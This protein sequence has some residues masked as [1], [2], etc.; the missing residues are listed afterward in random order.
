MLV[1]LSP[2]FEAL[3]YRGSDLTSLGALGCIFTCEAAGATT[4]SLALKPARAA[5]QSEAKAGQRPTAVGRQPNYARAH[6]RAPLSGFLA[7]PLD[8]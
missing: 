3:V 1:R 8:F 6:W 7:F 4:A 5:P 2:Q